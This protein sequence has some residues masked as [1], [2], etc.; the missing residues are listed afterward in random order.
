MI[1]I[2]PARFPH[3]GNL[4]RAIFAAYADSLEIDL[5]FQ[6]FQAE[7]DALPGQY[8]APQGQILLAWHGS[9]VVGCVA[10][11]ALEGTICEMKRLFVRPAARG[12]QTGRQLALA[13]GQCA[14][15]A[16]YTHLRL[17]T[18]SSMV[19]ALQLYA[20]LGFTDIPAYVFNPH[21]GARFLELDLTALPPGTGYTIP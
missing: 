15:Q 4:T 13:I 19:P 7:L 11:R 2:L 10:M 9:E 14:R 1:D 5:S 12:Q 8:G 21:A 17:D 3:Q 6:N 16:G 20:S 18:L